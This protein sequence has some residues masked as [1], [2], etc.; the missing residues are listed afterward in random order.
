L[1]ERTRASAQAVRRRA[2]AFQRKD[3]APL[4]IGLAPSISVSLVLDPIAEVSKFVPGLHVEFREAPTDELIELLLGGEIGT[5]LVG[6]VKDIPPRIDVWPLFQERYVALL[7]PTHE[8]A[9]RTAIGIE[10]L[11]H[12]TILERSGCDVLPKAQNLYFSDGTPNLGYCS[13]KDTHL[14]HMAAAGFGV[15]LAP[16]HMPHLSE[17]KAIP[18][19]G[20]PISREVRL[21]AVQ[22]RRYSPALEAFVKV[23]RLRNWSLE[24]V[25][26][27]RAEHSSDLDPRAPQHGRN[28]GLRDAGFPEPASDGR[29]TDR[30][31]Q[32]CV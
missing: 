28:D 27:R 26:E 15:I 14:Q 2:Q 5:A 8:L 19:E 30:R 9:D 18:I 29:V 1:L 21:L 16:E 11:R 3:V 25:P 12:A 22:G 32:Q 31:D 6:D 20:D 13:E 7:A 24:A 10:D 17:L 4:R 23:V